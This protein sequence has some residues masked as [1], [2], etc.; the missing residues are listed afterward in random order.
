MKRYIVIFIAI[1]FLNNSLLY[2]QNQ[3]C[4]LIYNPGFE[5]G[6]DGW[7]LF[8]SSTKLTKKEYS[9]KYA[10]KYINGGIEQEITNFAK[11]DGDTAYLL[12][13][14]FKTKGS[15]YRMW[16]GIEYFD[17]DW[18]LLKEDV[19]TLKRSRKYKVF[20]MDTTPPA[21]TVHVKLWT[22]SIAS[23]KAKT[24]IDDL[25]FQPID[26]NNDN[27]APKIKTI[28]DQQSTQGLEVHLAIEAQDED[29]DT[30]TY[31]ASDLPEGLHVNSQNGEIKG[32]P[33]QV[34]V[35]TVKVSVTDGQGGKDSKEF[36]WE[37]ISAVNIHCNILQNSS[38]ETD[39]N[40]W[41]VYG[42]NT[43]IDDGYDG[44]KAI[45]IKNG[46][47]DQ[48]S[49]YLDGGADTYQ[50]NGYYKTVGKTDGILVGMAFF[51]SN[52]NY[53]SGKTL[54]LSDSD[55]YTK[56][57]VNATTTKDVKYIQ[58]WI[59][60]T[61]ETNGGDIIIDNI[62]LSS[63]ACY[64]YALASSLPPKGLQPSQ[65][66][67]FVVIGFDDN[68]KAAGINWALD[69]FSNKYNSDGSQANVSFYMNTKG[70]YEQIDD[71]PAELL[72]AVKQLKNSTHEIG[73]HTDNHHSNLRPNESE[74]VFFSRI[75]KLDKSA[76]EERIFAANND[77]VNLAGVNIDSIKGFRAPYLLFNQ[78]SMAILKEN[79]FLYDCSIEEGYAPEFDGTNFRWPYQLDEG[80][81]GHN[82]SWYG[83]G[84]N[85][86]RVD[87][88]TIKGLW[89]LPNHALMVPK[90]SEASQYNIEPGLWNRLVARI[91]YLTDYKVTGL[92][93]NLWSLGGL[94]KT[95]MLGILKYN[96][97]LRL[98]GNRAPFMFGAH[99]QYYTKE[100]AD[101]YAPNA[102]LEDM[103][104]AISEFVDYALS[105]ND[106]RIQTGADI[107]KWCNDPKPLR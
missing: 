84:D 9:G 23:R 87:I 88:K 4:N 72:E 54:Y 48:T 21:N 80:S 47:L 12:E 64:D 86:E 13:G 40:G 8:T 75:K 70:F 10:I 46:G 105:K 19:L 25:S 58:G 66:P 82:E 98:K 104:E 77:L 31:S 45:K 102:T 17:Q 73:N 11:V 81:P 100:W 20:S 39:T 51:D 101:N 68:T 7:N 32:V 42:D 97:D 1:L 27:N 85:S 52:K 3:E 14:Y 57:I 44:I 65:V 43:L 78:H 33:T 103:K 99:S 59:W 71:N 95:E 2:A 18:S 38:F 106:V 50:F 60:S 37:I 55:T 96:L 90:D 35:F 76:W 16:V 22:Y 107:I 62:K 92:D 93:Y 26:C 29:G 28:P 67:Q 36:R 83:R 61:A 15:P 69:L 94:N 5:Q 74:E 53:L 24:Y 30:L 91:S 41:V 34:G 79:Q 49:E 56:F 63:S 6:T 89:E